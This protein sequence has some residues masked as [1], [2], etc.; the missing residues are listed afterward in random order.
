V[1]SSDLLGAQL[2]RRRLQRLVEILG[3]AV[4]AMT[5]EKEVRERAAG[6]GRVSPR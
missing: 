1:C 3:R 4:E 6:N 5:L 2:E